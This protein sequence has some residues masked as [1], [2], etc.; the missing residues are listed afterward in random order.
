MQDLE[1]THREIYDRVLAMEAKVDRLQQQTADV[2]AA[3]EAAR[4]AFQVL[5]WLARL[6]KPVMWLGATLAAAAAVWQNW[7]HPNG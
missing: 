6:A 7:R 3:F 2:V 4:G 1:V 5:E